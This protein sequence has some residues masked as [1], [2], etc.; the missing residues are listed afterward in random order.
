MSKEYNKYWIFSLTRDKLLT[1]MMREVKDETKWIRDTTYEACMTCPKL[2][3]A[4]IETQQA[5]DEEIEL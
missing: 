3:E 1:M 2:T 4:Q 5:L